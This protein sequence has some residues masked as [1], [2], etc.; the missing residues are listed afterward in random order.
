MRSS[1]QVSL[2]KLRLSAE[3]F[4]MTETDLASTIQVSAL[5][6]QF[7]STVPHHALAV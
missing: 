5:A 1:G 2:E 6:A 3:K 4:P 7:E